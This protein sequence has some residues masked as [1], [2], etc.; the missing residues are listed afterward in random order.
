MKT[1]R[2]KRFPINGEVWTE[3]WVP[4]DDPRLVVDDE[5]CAGTCDKNTHKIALSID[6]LECSHRAAALQIHERVHA[7]IR[8]YPDEWLA[9]QKGET[10]EDWEERIVTG[11]AD[12]IVS[13]FRGKLKLE[14]T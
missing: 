8:S 4:A 10:D 6:E 3:E 9:Q 13:S 11:I 12:G 7:A 14:Y 2:V 1:P 5:A